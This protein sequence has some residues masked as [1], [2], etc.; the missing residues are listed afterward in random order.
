MN[1]FFSLLLLIGMSFGQSVQAEPQLNDSV[2]KMQFNL[3]VDTR[4]NVSL[5]SSV[6]DY[7]VLSRWQLQDAAG[8]R[9]SVTPGK[10]TLMLSVA[11]PYSQ[12]MRLILRGERAVS[13]DLRYGERGSMTVKLLDAQL[14]GQSVQIVGTT[15]D[16][17]INGAA[18]DS[19]LLQP[20][21]TF[22]VSAKG[23][24]A[25]GKVLTAHLE[26]EPIL[27]KAEA[28]VS[29]RQTSEANLTVELME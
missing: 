13:G 6:V 11:C 9:N 12:K 14:D 2:S 17:A 28:R 23:Q 19:R 1:R 25:K 7:G 29:S 27:S 4:C 5:G 16:G 22:A 3:P 21:Q 20:G 10:R 26:I 15:P 18:T 8:D 24:L